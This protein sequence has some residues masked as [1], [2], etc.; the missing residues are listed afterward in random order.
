MGNT[1]KILIC[2]TNWLGDSIISMPAIQQFKKKNPDISISILVKPALK[3]LWEMHKDI[4]EVITYK[5][6]FAGTFAAARK[7]RDKNFDRAYIFPNSFRATVIPWCAGIAGRSGLHGKWRYMLL[8]DVVHAENI[9]G[10]HQVYE[11]FSILGIEPPEDIPVPVLTVKDDAVSDLLKKHNLES[12]V[13]YSALIPGAARGA[14][15]RWSEEYFIET[16]KYLA[17]KGMKVLVLGSPGERE[18]CGNVADKCT[19]AINLAGKTSLPE[20]VAALRLCKLVVCNDSGGMHL[21][22]AVG[23]NVV[24]VFGIT[25]SGKTGPLGEKSK[26]VYR[27]DISVSRDVPRNSEYAQKVLR[28]ITPDKVIK[29]IKEFK[30]FE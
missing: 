13:L 30:D 22:S 27:D 26:V 29:T 21:A 3:L 8:T 14:V 2:G 7:L 5:P 6:D 9:G 19:G 16:G 11:Y 20:F 12:D 17:G 24:A 25:D 10:Y 23:C 15:K 28:S 4:D 18:L 1:E